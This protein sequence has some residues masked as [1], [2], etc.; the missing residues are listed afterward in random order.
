[1]A[2]YIETFRKVVDPDEL[3]HLG[4]MNVQY[5]FAAI[6][7]AITSFQIEL[8]LT[9]TDMRDVVAWL[10]CDPL[11]PVPVVDKTT[12]AIG[13]SPD[14]DLVLRHKSVSRKQAWIEVA[15]R[16]LNFRDKGSSNGTF[17]NG[18]KVSKKRLKEGDRIL[19]GTSIIKLVAASEHSS[20]GNDL[21]DPVTGA[22]LTPQSVPRVT[23][24][25]GTTAT[26]SI[27]GLLV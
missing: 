15:D 12:L 21:R 20:P 26:G 3:D 25:G 13:R 27:S 10:C 5:Y 16:V 17:V 18:E 8:G 7:S 11:D 22:L 1:M 2:G 6:G 9:P 23:R 24:H 14:C 19:V 4:H